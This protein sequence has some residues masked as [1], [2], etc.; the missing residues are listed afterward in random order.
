MNGRDELGAWFSPA[1]VHKLELLV[2]EGIYPRI[3]SGNSA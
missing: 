3:S 2:W 1:R